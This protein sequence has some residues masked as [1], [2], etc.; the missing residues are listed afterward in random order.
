MK[1]ATSF[2]GTRGLRF[3]APDVSRGLM[4][5][6]IALANIPFWTSVTRS[7]AP[8]DAA[9]M[10]WLWMRTLLVDHRAYPLFSLLFGF[11]LAT[12]VNRRIASGTQ[13][14]LQSLPGVEAGR[15]PTSQEEFW[16]REQATVD[17]R[18]LVRRRGAWMI[19]FGAAHAALFSGDI[20]GTYGLAAVVFAGWLTR[21]HR[22]R[23]MAV[24]AV[25]T[26]ATIST[27]YTM[28]S[29]VAAQG[30]TAA[31][32]MKQGAGESATTLLSYV[33]GS[34]TSWAGNSVATVLF[35]MVVPAMFLG[36]RLADTDLI[37]H[38]ERHRRLLTAV[39]LGGLGVGAAGGIGYGLW[40]TG[41][42]LAA[43]TAPLHEVTG[44]VGACGW[45]ALLALYAGGPR[46]D[47]RLTGLR[48]LASNV[49]R[50]S[51]TAY[52]SQTFL[53]AIIFLALPALTG[54]E[55]HLGEARAAGIAAAVWLATVGLCA[56][57]ERGGH[58]G[59]FET[60]L[61][62]AVARSER[63]RRLPAAPV[64]V[65]STGPVATPDAYDLVH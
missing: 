51:M 2:T 15:E 58:A 10:A 45:L 3:P 37:A 24:S 6:F 11:G 26:A 44:L 61:R 13:S 47:G 43:W 17:A 21:K 22:K 25:V 18:R 20:I 46:E 27:M 36:A 16:A 34:I 56:A 59:P 29:H 39:G 5:L 31:A 32:V 35:S 8:G 64:A 9:D 28:G 52:L 57:L 14:Y 55:L 4:L 54:I 12:M 30:L 50:R 63:R 41:G 23:A 62:T 65:A 40:A 42:T 60:L 49:G 19:L 38:P 1:L 48:K 7:S 53:F 33:S